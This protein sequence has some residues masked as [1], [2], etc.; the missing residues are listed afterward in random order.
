MKFVD[1]NH[2]QLLARAMDSYTLRQRVT[3]GNIA[4]A[5]TPGYNKHRVDF[6][7]ELQRAKSNDGVRG[8]KEVTPSIVET[9]DKVVL[10][11]ELL[12][13]ADTQARVQLVTRSLRHHFEMLKNGITG[14]NR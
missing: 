14:I 2:S 6:E 11:D 8:M 4:N 9:D 7:A 10:E 1:S 5:D 3:A 13:M 12:E